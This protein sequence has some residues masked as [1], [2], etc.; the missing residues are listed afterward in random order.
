MAGMRSYLCPPA[1]L[2]CSV[3]SFPGP[4]PST[5]DPPPVL[6]LSKCL[7]S[8]FVRKMGYCPL[9]SLT[10]GY[11]THSPGFSGADPAAPLWLRGV[12]IL[13]SRKFRQLR[14]RGAP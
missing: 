2:P 11:S 14:L 5:P 12:E 3:D 6:Q 10:Q 13:L 8:V 1:C 7:R 9:L 4:A